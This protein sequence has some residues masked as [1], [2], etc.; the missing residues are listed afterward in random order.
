MKSNLRWLAVALLF[1]ITTTQAAGSNADSMRLAEQRAA[2]PRNIARLQQQLDA[3]S[4]DEFAVRAVA[5]A[6]DKRAKDIL[7]KVLLS[8]E[9]LR[10]SQPSADCVFWEAASGLGRGGDPSAIVPLNKFLLT[11]FRADTFVA[12]A[13]P[14]GRSEWSGGN[15]NYWRRSEALSTALA[16]YR[17]GDWRE[18]LPVLDTLVQRQYAA[19]QEP[20]QLLLAA[21]QLPSD[22]YSKGDDAR[23]ATLDYLKHCC[24][25][26]N[27]MVR[28]AAAEALAPFAPELAYNTAAALIATGPD[29]DPRGGD[30]FLVAHKAYAVRVLVTLDNAEARSLLKKL[31]QS[32]SQPMRDAVGRYLGRESEG[33]R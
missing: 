10:Y 22:R 20:Y 11:R 21:Y 17:L 32:G 12:D 13:R 24:T 19:G 33:E 16:L 6:E 5:N 28:G 14:F 15:V 30:R 27:L 18:A 4:V 31:A 3:W 25:S 7:V 29:T 9:T 26:P 1:A 8:P 2:L 23:E